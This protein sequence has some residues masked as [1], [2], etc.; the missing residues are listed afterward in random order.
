MSGWVKEDAFEKLRVSVSLALWSVI[1][2]M[3]FVTVYDILTYAHKCMSETTAE[4][5]LEVNAGLF[6]YTWNHYGR[7]K[8]YT[9]KEFLQFNRIVN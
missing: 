3:Q 8:S 1:S 9:Q 5:K 7:G 6:R 4:N 2:I